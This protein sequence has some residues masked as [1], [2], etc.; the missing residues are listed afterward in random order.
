MLKILL[1]PVFQYAD[2]DDDDDEQKNQLFR[3]SVFMVRGETKTCPLASYLR[4]VLTS[5]S[6]AIISKSL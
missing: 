4:Y 1:Q 5:S 3:V 2:L 6:Q